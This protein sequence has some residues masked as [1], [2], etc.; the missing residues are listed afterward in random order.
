MNKLF[1]LIPLI[2]INEISFSQTTVT[3]DKEWTKR[4]TTVL[5][6]TEADYI[7]RIGDV[8]NLGFGWPEEFDPFC[9]AMTQ[10]HEYPW[11]ADPNEMAGFDRI[12]LSSKYNP[13]IAVAC[14]E[15]D[16][17]SVSY[18]ALLTK[19]AEF[20]MNV[21]ALKNADIKNAYIQFFIDDFQAPSMCSKFQITINGKRF[22]EAERF[23]NAIDQTGPVGKLITIPVPE[24][25]YSDLKAD[26]L[27]LKVDESLGTGDGFA[28][29]F[30]RI[31]VNRKRE[32]TCKGD[33][34]GYVRDKETEEPIAGARVWTTEGLEAT[35]DS[36]GR[37]EIKGVPTGFEIVS[38]SKTG[39]VDNNT[40]ADV[41]ES[42]NWELTILLEKSVSA[43]FGGK[44]ISAGES[45]TLSNILFD[46]G[47]ADLRAESKTELD[48]IVKFM[49][50]NPKAEIELSGHTSSEG[51][52]ALNRSLSYK[53]VKSCKDY[54]VLKGIDSGRIT[55]I[56]Y[57]P[58]KPVAGNDTEE[59]R[60]KNRRVEMRVLKL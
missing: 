15:H 11:T 16:G 49:Q 19:P 37:F 20:T 50:D 59:N 42:G 22:T 39:Y 30:I 45:V 48:K 7:I 6:T 47:K 2:S 52:A 13:D 60:A 27:K 12:L 3:T 46:Q 41:A 18:D 28:L 26:K 23:F 5:N 35:T 14:N 21:S 8:D 29:D 1:I 10:S 51:D 40:T 38:G 54:I 57:G 34:Y 25:F 31:L 43:D 44:S 36:E 24:E 33:I 58:D 56:G 17:Y 55:T 32:N 9:G 53:R 4:E